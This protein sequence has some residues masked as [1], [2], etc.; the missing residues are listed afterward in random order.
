MG[1]FRLESDHDNIWS[2][3]LL[4]FNANVANN[5]YSYGFPSGFDALTVDCH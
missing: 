4:D 2:G 3:N 5:F 1:S